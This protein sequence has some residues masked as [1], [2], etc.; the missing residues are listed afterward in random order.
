MSSYDPEFHD[1]AKAAPDSFDPTPK[2]NGCW[3]YGCVFVVVSMV[4]V[5]L[6]LA[7]AAFVV[8]R[9]VTQY[10]EDYT[11]VAPVAL[12]KVE[13]P[14]AQRKSAVE[15]ARRF[16]DALKEKAATE[17]LILTGDDLNAL[18]QESAKL[19]D[20]VY[21]TIDDDK[22]KAQVSLPLDEFFNTRLTRGRYLNGEA[23][24]KATIQDG[25]AKIE[26]ES[27]AVDGKP[28]PEFVRD[29]FARPSILNL[30]KEGDQDDL[31]HQI[32]SFEIKDGEIVVTARSAEPGPG[33][34]SDPPGPPAPSEAPKPAASAD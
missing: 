20:R 29:M 28:L 11:A 15:R 9:T 13:I 23:E 7:V 3:F 16:R 30:D 10:V 31:L 22:V 2:R 14:E 27:I 19:K 26:V 17:P 6:G 33:T 5:L 4:V 25:E 34:N 32:A 24:L 1:P 21:L 18:V 8:Y 12:P